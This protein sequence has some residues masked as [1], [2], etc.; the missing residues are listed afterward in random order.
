MSR[1]SAFFF[2]GR[3]MA[4]VQTP[5]ATETRICSDIVILL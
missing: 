3:C 4:T 1:V 5:S 2:S